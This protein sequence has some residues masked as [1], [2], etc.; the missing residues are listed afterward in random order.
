[1]RATNVYPYDDEDVGPTEERGVVEKEECYWWK[2]LEPRSDSAVHP[3][4]NYLPRM[5]PLDVVLHGKRHGTDGQDSLRG[6]REIFIPGR[7]NRHRDTDTYGVLP[8]LVQKEP[9]WEP[10]SSH[11]FTTYPL[12]R[13]RMIQVHRRPGQT[14]LYQDHRPLQD[15]GLTGTRGW[16]KVW[17]QDPKTPRAQNLIVPWTTEYKS[18]PNRVLVRGDS[19]D[20]CLT[21]PKHTGKINLL[22]ETLTLYK[23]ST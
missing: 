19:L 1:M 15:H 13:G 22:T 7:E 14:F 20:E 6:L 12:L 11:L 8:F 16:G 9:V 2:L 4:L 23:V 10:C 21:L 3:T 5:I 17:F 18:E